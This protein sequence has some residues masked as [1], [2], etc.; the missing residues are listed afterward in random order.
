[1]FL[2]VWLVWPTVRTLFQKSRLSP[3]WARSRCGRAVGRVGY[4][5]YWAILHHVKSLP[6][7]RRLRC[8]PSGGTHRMSSGWRAMVGLTR[9]RDPP[10]TPGCTCV[11]H[12]AFGP[13]ARKNIP[14]E[15]NPP[16]PGKNGGRE[17]TGSIWTKKSLARWVGIIDAFIQ[18]VRGNPSEM[19]LITTSHLLESIGECP[20]ELSAGFLRI[21]AVPGHAEL[22]PL[23]PDAQEGAG[24]RRSY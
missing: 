2:F 6:R 13:I 14:S 16:L 21:A 10:E 20:R 19:A 3:A 22:P 8:F 24:P 23:H 11:A 12:W 7:M 5:K 9:F 4:P 17:A 1:M 15:Q 18:T